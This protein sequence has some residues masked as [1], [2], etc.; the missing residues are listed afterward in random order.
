MSIEAIRFRMEGALCVLQVQERTGGDIYSYGGGLGSSRVSVEWRDAN[1]TDLLDV[2]RFT[3]DYP[4]LLARFRELQSRLDAAS[5]MA[6]NLDYE[7]R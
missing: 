7:A 1:A 5:P 3:R 4:D 6:V 2:A